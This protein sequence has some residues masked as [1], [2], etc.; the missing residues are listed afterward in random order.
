MK[1][2]MIK[3]Y[4]V[5]PVRTNCHILYR[6]GEEKALVF[7]PGASGRQLYEE[8]TKLGLKV[9]GIFITHGHFDHICGVEELKDL[10]GAKVYGPSSEKRFFSDVQYNH[11]ALYGLDCTIDPDVYL[12]DLETV[13]AGGFSVQ[14]IFT[15]GHTEGGCC[16]YLPEEGILISGDT[17]FHQSVGRTDMETGNMDLLEKSIREKLYVLPDETVVY[18]GHESPTTIGYE[19]THNFFVR[20]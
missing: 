6:E 18:P 5:G 11:S 19:K 14:T 7:D 2:A 3:T 8:I 4:I 1:E 10:S 13:Q 12:E 16:Y 15:P 9:E 20:A 17:L